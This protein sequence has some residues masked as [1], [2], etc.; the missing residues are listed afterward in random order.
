MQEKEINAGEGEQCRRRGAVFASIETGQHSEKLGKRGACTKFILS[1][2]W[3]ERGVSTLGVS[4]RSGD[5]AGS[6]EEREL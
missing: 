3:E 2:A 6:R 5:L 4:E 1:V